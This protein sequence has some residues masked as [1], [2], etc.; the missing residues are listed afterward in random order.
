VKKKKMKSARNTSSNSLYK[1]TSCNFRRANNDM[2]AALKAGKSE[3]N[4]FEIF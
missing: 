3:K 2:L 1:C 4:N